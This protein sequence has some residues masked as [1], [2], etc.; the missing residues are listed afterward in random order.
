MNKL[1]SS[2]LKSGKEG[3]QAW[4]DLKAAGIERIKESSMSASQRDSMGNPVLS[5]DKLIRAIRSFDESGK[6][7][8]LYGKKQAQIIRDLGEIASVIYTAPPGAINTSNT[9]S[10]LM[11]ALDS[12]GTF[13]VT[14]VPAPVATAIKEASKYV[15]NKK[16]KARINE[17]LKGVD[18]ENN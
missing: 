2:L 15:K 14:G 12:L 1:R 10:A 16:V 5:P 6:L 17:A 3:K 7:E 18:R 4:S 8:S 13:A 9:A 11:V